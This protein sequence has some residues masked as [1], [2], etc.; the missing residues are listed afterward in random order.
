MYTLF[1]ASPPSSTKWAQVPQCLGDALLHVMQSP[2]ITCLALSQIANFPIVA[3]RACVNLTELTISMVD[4]HVS[5]VDEQAA[6]T[7]TPSF[8]VVRIPQLQTFTCEIYSDQYAMCLLNARHPINGPV[9]DFSNVR[10]LCLE[11][12]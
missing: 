4:F 3:L 9:L 1:S 8:D 10:M 12:D 5:T 2:L 7:P 11:V 6:L